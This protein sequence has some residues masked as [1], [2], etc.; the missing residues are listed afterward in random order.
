[1]NRLLN[2]QKLIDVGFVSAP[3]SK[4]LSKFKLNMRLPDTKSFKIIG[5]VRL[6]E[7]KDAAG[8]IKLYNSQL[9]K[10]LVKQKMS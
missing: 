2:V 7:K 8:V 1:M 3:P 6:M 4:Q 9:E 10:C 5:T